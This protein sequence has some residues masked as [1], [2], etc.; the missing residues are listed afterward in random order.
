MKGPRKFVDSRTK[1]K[2]QIS[3]LPIASTKNLAPKMTSF[4]QE[5]KENPFNNHLISMFPTQRLSFAP[6]SQT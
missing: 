6:E 5:W 2:S 4:L 3:C 1:T